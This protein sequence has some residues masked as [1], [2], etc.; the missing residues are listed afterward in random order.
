MYETLFVYIVLLLEFVLSVVLCDRTYLPGPRRSITVRS[1]L[2]CYFE[3][4]VRSLCIGKFAL[5]I[6]WL[7]DFLGIV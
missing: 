6:Y 7:P 3:V 1:G 2:L 5:F 4:L